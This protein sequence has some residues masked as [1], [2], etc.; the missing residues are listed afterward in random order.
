MPSQFSISEYFSFRWLQRNPV[1]DN[2]YNAPPLDYAPSGYMQPWQCG[3][4]DHGSDTGQVQVLSDYELTLTIRDYYTDAIIATPAFTV[5]A[6]SGQTFS[7]YTASFDF[8]ALSPGCY[9]GSISYT[10]EDEIVQYYDT[11]G[12]DVEPFHENTKLYEVTNTYNDK[13]IVFVNADQSTIIINL[14]CEGLLRSPIPKS[15][16]E[17]FTDQ[18]NNLTQLSAVPY[19]TIT[20]LIGYEEIVI[21]FWLIKKINLL[22]SLNKV[23]INGEYFTAI[24]GSEW[25]PTRPSNQFN[26]DGFWEIDIQPNNNYD[27]AQFD[28]TGSTPGSEFRVIIDSLPYP[29][30]TEAIL[31]SGFF[32]PRMKL[33]S[34][35]IINTGGDAFTIYLGTTAP[36]M[37]VA[38]NDITTVY[39]ETPVGGE[40]NNKAK[41][42]VIN[43]LFDSLENVYIEF[44]TGVNIDM[45]VEYTDYV[46]PSVTPDT[47]NTR[48]S[49]DTLYTFVENTSGHFEREFDVATGLGKVGTDHEN[50]VLAGTAGTLDVTDMVV[51]AWDKTMPL[52]RDT[53]IG[54]DTIIQTPSQ[55]A[56]HEHLMFNGDS[57]N[58]GGNDLA[59]PITGSP[60]YVTYQRNANIKRDYILAQSNSVPDRGPTAP[61]TNPVDPMVITPLSIILPQFYYIKPTV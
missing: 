32:K 42:Y 28:T 8:S 38:S 12:W 26:E 58:A 11:D 6:I 54:A 21:P 22:Y 4:D 51:R 36:V 20:D 43:H 41:V 55:V 13:G 7:A 57:Q 53:S 27:F 23:K 19:E 10:D 16:D 31:I 50:C 52:L 15:D 18:T 2:R 9:Y 1:F 59:P 24:S 29:G 34:L 56:A 14:R 49:E 60:M 46:A 47:G 25:K 30:T 61:M 35:N 48:W 33:N 5:T 3:D 45:D 37:G 17:D 40:T 44:P 39:V